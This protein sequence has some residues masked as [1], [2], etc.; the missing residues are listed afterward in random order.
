MA[1]INVKPPVVASNSFMR[2]SVV[3]RTR[4]TVQKCIATEGVNLYGPKR[5]GISEHLYY[6]LGYEIDLSAVRG[7]TVC[8]ALSSSV[9]QL[10]SADVARFEKN[11]EAC[12]HLAGEWAPDMSRKDKRH[13]ESNIDRYCSAAQKQRKLL[14]VKYK[15]D[16]QVVKKLDQYEAVTGYQGKRGS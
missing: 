16:E 10:K 3:R 7:E 8:P 9:D 6:G 1:L 5:D 15:N 14:R 13:I 2:A 4:Y 12:T 11:A